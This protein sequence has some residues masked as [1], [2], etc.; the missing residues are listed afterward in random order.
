MGKEEMQVPLYEAYLWENISSMSNK[1][2]FKLFH[3]TSSD[4]H[5]LESAIPKG[6]KEGI[7]LTLTAL[8]L[9]QKTLVLC[10]L[11]QM[12]ASNGL[13][14]SKG[15]VRENGMRELSC[16]IYGCGASSY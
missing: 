7:M 2:W 13:I 1:F 9:V 8:Q 15:Y 14:A 12:R 5:P 4:F 16:I 10:L 3:Y 6:E 11:A